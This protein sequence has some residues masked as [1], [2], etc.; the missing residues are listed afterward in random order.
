MGKIYN[1][2]LNS[3]NATTVTTANS[4]LTYNI[5][6]ADLLPPNRRFKL[7]FAFM[8]SLIY[9]NNNSFPAITTNLLGNTYR[10]ATNGYQQSYYLGHLRPIPVIFPNSTSF[11][12]YNNYT[13]SITDNAPIYLE[14][15]PRDNNLQVVISNGILATEFQDNY[16]TIA[17]AGTLTQSGFILTVATATAGVITIGTI[18]VVGT[19]PLSRTITGFITGTGGTGTYLC[20]VSTTT[21]AAIAY[22]FVADTTRGNMSP[23]ILNL[24][25]EEL[26]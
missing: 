1:V 22:T 4:N 11:G 16:L 17:G 3:A 5:D 21:A 18:L 20:D 19:A 14:N 13:A 8:S 26:D 10:P 25:F 24:S 2:Q 12:T 6:W 7:T 9:G 23:Y 15:R